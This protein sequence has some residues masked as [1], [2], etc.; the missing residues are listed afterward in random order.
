METLYQLS[1]SPEWNVERIAAA[2][3]SDTLS[4][5]AQLAASAV[6]GIFG[7]SV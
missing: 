7:T 5:W 2:R 3:S 1:Y 6:Q 4:P